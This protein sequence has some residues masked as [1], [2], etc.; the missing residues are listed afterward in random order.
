MENIR[1][2]VLVIGAGVS[3]WPA[4]V[5]AARSGAKVLLL[6]ATSLPGGQPVNQ[7]VAM[8]DGGPRSGIVRE[9]LEQ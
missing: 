5:A 1:C 3:G 7:F 9:Y 2:D 8:P 4:A 6:E